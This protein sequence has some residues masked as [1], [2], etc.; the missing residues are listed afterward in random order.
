MNN[1]HIL[2]ILY[3]WFIRVQKRKQ[4]KMLLIRTFSKKKMKNKN[5]QTF[6][7]K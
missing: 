6:Y 5:S 4:G 1:E 2:Y 3:L 7:L